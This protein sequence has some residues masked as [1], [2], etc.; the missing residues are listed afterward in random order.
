MIWWLFTMPSIYISSCSFHISFQFEYAILTLLLSYEKFL[1]NWV[2]NR[3]WAE[4]FFF[5]YLFFFSC[6][7]EAE[8]CNVHYESSVLYFI[9]ALNYFAFIYDG[10]EHYQKNHISK[11][12]MRSESRENEYFKKLKHGTDE[13][14]RLLC[15]YIRLRTKKKYCAK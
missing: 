7:N 5:P 1:L 9:V 15:I 6:E 14:M 3:I 10:I 4:I 12:T 8:N 13:M 11:L 2:L